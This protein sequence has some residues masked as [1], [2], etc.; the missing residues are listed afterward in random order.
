MNRKATLNH[1]WMNWAGSSNNGLR[2]STRG[3]TSHSRETFISFDKFLLFCGVELARHDLGLAILH[4]YPLQQLD[5]SRA[6]VTD[7]VRLPIHSPTIV[8]VRG[9]A[10][11]THLL[12]SCCCEA[13][14]SQ[15]VPL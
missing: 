8:V 15:A 5:Q 6:G 14:S 3:R 2:T 4:A 11:A 9:S 12:S 10:S 1:R 13:V 7:A